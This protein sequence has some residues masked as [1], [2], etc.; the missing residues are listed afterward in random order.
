MCQ[1]RSSS[2]LVPHGHLGAAPDGAS[3]PASL[4][5]L[6]SL[7]GSACARTLLLQTPTIATKLLLPLGCFQTPVEEVPSVQKFAVNR[8][9]QLG[10]P[11]I[12]AHHQSSTYCPSRNIADTTCLTADPGGRG[13]Q[14]SEVCGQPCQQLGK[15]A[16]VAQQSSTYC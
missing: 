5:S 8:A 4:P 1:L 6:L 3:R 14:C 15:P 9:R 12:V 16:I 11:A 7:R 10:K 2:T 13:A